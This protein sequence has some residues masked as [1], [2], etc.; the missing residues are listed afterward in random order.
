MQAFPS[1]Q[2]ANNLFL[3]EGG[4]DA[5]VTSVV[6]PN[7]TQAEVEVVTT[8]VATVGP[9]DVNPSKERNADLSRTDRSTRPTRTKI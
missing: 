3:S 2:V 5:D 7:R 9:V 4:D 1:V 6:N 8:G